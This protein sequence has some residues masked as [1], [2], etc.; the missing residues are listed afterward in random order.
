MSSA[1]RAQ[2]DRAAGFAIFPGPDGG[3]DHLEFHVKQQFGE[4]ST[5]QAAKILSFTDGRKAFISFGSVASICNTIMGAGILTLPYAFAHVGVALGLVLMIFFAVQTVYVCNILRACCEFTGQPSYSGLARAFFGWNL[6]LAVDILLAVYAFA[7]CIGYLAVLGDESAIIFSLLEIE[8]PYPWM[9][10]RGVLLSL[11]TCVVVLPLCL[12]RNMKS[13]Q[14]IGFLAISAAIYIGAV[15]L[16][17]KPDLSSSCQMAETASYRCVRNT[18]VVEPR[19]AFATY[20]SQASCAETCE[21]VESF[22]SAKPVWINVGPAVFQSL[23]LFVYSFNC[24]VPFIPIF[25]EMK[26]KKG[27]R[28][29][30]TLTAAVLLCFVVY[31]MCAFGG[32]WA[33][34]GRSCPNILDCYPAADALILPARIALVILVIPTIPLFNYVA[35]QCIEKQVG[36]SAEA[37]DAG[38]GSQRS[39]ASII[40]T[41]ALVAAANTIAVL[42]QNLSVVLGL[43]GALGGSIL[44]WILPGLFLLKLGR[45]GVS[46]DALYK[47]RA[48]FM[49]PAALA[50]SSPAHRGPSPSASD[51]QLSES[52]SLPLLAGC[53]S[54]G[55]RTQTAQRPNFQFEGYTLVTIGTLLLVLGTILTLF[56][57]S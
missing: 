33:F 23:P 24:V 42:T 13:L 47:D 8:L 11:L 18:C 15:V 31:C 26:R 41:I 52:P 39:I 25:A 48:L 44:V 10:S 55:E 14:Y 7:S 16:V 20:T 3:L 17:Q 40:L 49:S 6:A 4:V 53:E 43:T 29:R 35:R 54:P 56:A 45:A 12:Q 38:R 27:T 50:F 21:G 19:A 2:E 30:T 36:L 46:K 57:A 5:S 37:S 34:C 32:Y 51:S 1:V 22:S 28:V 9:G